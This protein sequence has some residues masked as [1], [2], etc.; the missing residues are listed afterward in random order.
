MVLLILS[1]T[2]P[3]YSPN[4][5]KY[6]F[7]Q[8][9]R[10]ETD[11][12]PLPLSVLRSTRALTFGYG[13]AVRVGVDVGAGDAEVGVIY[14]TFIMRCYTKKRITKAPDGDH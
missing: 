14:I 5:I 12:S 2:S 7:S 8:G 4:D 3:S 6:T 1:L 13:C 10:L 11:R 9:P